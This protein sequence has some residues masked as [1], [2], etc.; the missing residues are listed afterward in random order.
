[1]II[2]PHDTQ[3]RLQG[4]EGIVRDLG[5]GRGQPRDKRGL[6]C[7]GKADHPDVGEKFELEMH[8]AL[9]PRTSK[10]GAAGRPVGGAHEARIAPPAACAAGHDNALA[11]CGQIP[12]PFTRVTVGHHGAER[13]AQDGVIAGGAVLVG[14]LA[15]LAALR[16][17]VAL[18]VEIEQGGDGGIR[19]E[20]D[21]APVTAVASVGAAARHELLTPEADAA[22]TPVAALDEDVDLVD[23]HQRTRE[24]RAL[25]GGLLG[26]ADVL[27]VALAL[28]AN[29]TVG[30]R[31]QRVVGAQAHVDPRLEAGAPLAHDDAARRDELPAEALDAQP[32]GIGIAPVT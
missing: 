21:A 17:V 16:R 5:L 18:V 6:S 10:I 30:G 4:G 24:R 22:R 20:E 2:D 9:G 13:H 14:A 19:F 12:Q 7:I 25:S 27:V 11:R 1:M 26:D 31:E 29:V 3:S 8:P 23:E 28:E 32:L 15:V